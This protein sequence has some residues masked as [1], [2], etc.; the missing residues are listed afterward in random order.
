M[1]SRRCKEL[2]VVKIP[3]SV[4]AGDSLILYFSVGLQGSNSLH[5]MSSWDVRVYWRPSWSSP[6]ARI[7]IYVKDAHV[8]DARVRRQ[9]QENDLT[10][11]N[12]VRRIVR[13]D[14]FTDPVSFE[15]V[16]PSRK[17]GQRQTH[18]GYYIRESFGNV[19]QSDDSVF[20][21]QSFAK[22]RD[23]LTRQRR[24]K[25]KGNLKMLNEAKARSKKKVKKDT[26]YSHSMIANQKNKLKSQK[27]SKLGPTSKKH[28]WKSAGHLKNKQDRYSHDLDKVKLTK[29][30]RNLETTSRERTD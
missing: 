6:L 26:R 16:K 17:R 5:N 24:R 21:R 1:R 27:N 10:N 28:S 30:K 2:L 13:G 14:D 9:M 12:K 3:S 18:E 22:V 15:D 20:I 7:T 29:V 19:R 11:K 25:H 4:Q 8:K 23:S